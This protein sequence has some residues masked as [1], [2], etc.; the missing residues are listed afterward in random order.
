MFPRHNCTVLTLWQF[1]SENNYIFPDDWINELQYTYVSCVSEG[2]L[3]EWNLARIALAKS[4]GDRRNIESRVVGLLR[5]NARSMCLMPDHEALIAL[6]KSQ[7]GPRPHSYN[8]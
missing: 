8:Q 4:E 2:S 7:S 6:C 5:L 1:I 3:A